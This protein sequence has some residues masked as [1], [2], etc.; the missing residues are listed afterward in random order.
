MN[1]QG[2]FQ[3]S[4]TPILEQVVNFGQMRHNVL[5]G[6]IANISTPGYEFRD[7]PPEAFQAM[8]KKA[9]EAESASTS[10]PATAASGFEKP[11]SGK[12]AKNHFGGLKSQIDDS[13][14]VNSENR[15]LEYQVA[16]ITK[17]QMQHNMALTI[18]NN[19]FRLIQSA[20]SERA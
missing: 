13:L 1:V 5:A 7:L 3:N 6:N 11:H 18:L 17:N 2:M 14:V 4:T 10:H 12:E 8:L 15:S 19:Q 9:V 16:E 20:I